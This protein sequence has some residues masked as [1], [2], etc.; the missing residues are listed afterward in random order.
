MFLACQPCL[1][2]IRGSIVLRH[3]KPHITALSH[4]QSFGARSY[5]WALFAAGF[6]LKLC[7]KSE[8]QKDSSLLRF[9]RASVSKY[10]KTGGVTLWGHRQ[11][12]EGPVSR[13]SPLSEGPRGL[14][15]G[16]VHAEHLGKDKCP[17]T[18]WGANVAGRRIFTS[19]SLELPCTGC[20]TLGESHHSPSHVLFP[21]S[22]NTGL[23]SLSERVV[24]GWTALFR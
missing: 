3:C 8:K 20:V 5:H 18:K 14:A 13:S 10:S 17:L 9:L 7:R 23:G 2:S 22:C 11:D 21:M 1:S 15:T 24:W 12:K 19:T 16:A 6:E 4:R